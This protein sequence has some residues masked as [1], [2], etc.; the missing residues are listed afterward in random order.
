MKQITAQ[1]GDRLDQ[2]ANDEYGNLSHFDEVMEA[3]QHLAT[4]PV[5]DDGDIVYLPAITIV[6]EEIKVQTLWT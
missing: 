4:K 6:A 2:L 3:N 1:N 5:L